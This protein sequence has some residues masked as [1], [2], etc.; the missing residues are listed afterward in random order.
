MILNLRHGNYQ[1]K[2]FFTGAVALACPGVAPPLVR[3]LK[4]N[5]QLLS[6]MVQGRYSESFSVSYFRM[7]CKHVVTVTEERHFNDEVHDTERL[8]DI[9]C[10]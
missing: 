1:G 7:Y 6:P 9:S 5:T 4:K 3:G 8:P 2:H 10:H